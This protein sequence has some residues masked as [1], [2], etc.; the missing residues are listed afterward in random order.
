MCKISYEKCVCFILLVILAVLR[1]SGFRIDRL[2]MSDIT[3]RNSTYTSNSLSSDPSDF[4]SRLFFTNSAR[5]KREE[6][7]PY[8]TNKF[9]LTNFQ[10]P[11]RI[12]HSRR[13][14]AQAAKRP[15]GRIEVLIIPPS[16][17][18]E[19]NAKLSTLT[20]LASQRIAQIPPSD[21]HQMQPTASMVARSQR[22]SKRNRRQRKKP[23]NCQEQDVAR[24]AY[25]AN[26]VVLAKAES[27]SSNRVHNYSV[28]FRI[29]EV[30][31]KTSWLD[32]TLRLTFLN[33][34]KR[35]NCESEL[36]GR[37]HGLVKAQIQQSKE[38]FL[39]LNST[40]RHRYSVLGM[41]VLKKKKRVRDEV[42][43][44]RVIRP[45]FGK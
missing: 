45:G 5:Y 6:P 25:M 1:C 16:D 26:T 41:P 7:G 28:S 27:M 2:A 15:T 39:F 24:K 37:T 42:E 44:N 32:S 11:Y 13:N 23:S 4:L 14:K 30:F 22:S 38:Y 10:R 19:S 36:N 3:K 12:R 29:I 43:I 33:E 17:K 21:Y 8:E 20:P 9:L 40:G 31:K 35:M 18:T 34:T